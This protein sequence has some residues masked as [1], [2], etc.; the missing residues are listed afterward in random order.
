M[1]TTTFFLYFD[2]TDIT[3]LKNTNRL[4]KMWNNRIILLATVLLGLINYTKG[5]F[6][7]VDAH[8]E[9]C[10]FDKAESGTKMGRSRLFSL[11]NSKFCVNK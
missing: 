5:Y 6:V 2:T 10:F 4:S 9:E 11:L 8:S 7:T 1:T 3:W